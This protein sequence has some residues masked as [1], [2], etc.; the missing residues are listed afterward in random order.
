MCILEKKVIEYPKVWDIMVYD[1]LNP[2]N[3][4]VEDTAVN[5]PQTS[6]GHQHLMLVS[7]ST[8]RYEAS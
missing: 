6:N 7:G 4:Y 5:L 3:M 8:S 2:G 1:G